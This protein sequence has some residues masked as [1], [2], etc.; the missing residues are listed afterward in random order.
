MKKGYWVW[1]VYTE[2]LA[3]Q[4]RQAVLA[5]GAAVDRRT[6]DITLELYNDDKIQALICFCCA[7]V[8]L[9]F[10]WF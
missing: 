3:I 10:I 6:F 8:C 4:E 5:V 9:S 2:A 1:D 7:W